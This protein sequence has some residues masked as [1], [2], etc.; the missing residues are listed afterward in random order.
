MRSVFLGTLEID[1]EGLSGTVRGNCIS[2]T[3]WVLVTSPSKD[4]R[5][6]TISWTSSSSA[7]SFPSALGSALG[8]LKSL[9]RLLGAR[10]YRAGRAELARKIGPVPVNWVRTGERDPSLT[11]GRGVRSSEPLARPR[12]VGRGKVER[13]GEVWPVTLPDVREGVLDGPDIAGNGFRAGE[14]GVE[15]ETRS[16][17]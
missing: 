9:G 7:V 6:S 5:S 15:G 1:L 3:R 8:V 17:R 11:R 2:P 13:M 4:I 14:E 12:V 16:S 10:E